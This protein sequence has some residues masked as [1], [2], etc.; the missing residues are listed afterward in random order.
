MRMIATVRGS[1]PRTARSRC[2]C[3]LHTASISDD[4]ILKACCAIKKPRAVNT[5]GAI[6]RGLPQ[7]RL[8]GWAAGG[9]GGWACRPAGLF[10]FHLIAGDRR[11]N[12]GSRVELIAAPDC[13]LGHRSPILRLQFAIKKV[14][15]SFH[16]RYFA[17]GISSVLFKA[18]FGAKLL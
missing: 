18:V 9:V 1:R 2:G 10:D 12:A 3:S 8:L 15:P 7:L 17:L 6:W 11:R 14:C 5:L 13:L 16:V 4:E